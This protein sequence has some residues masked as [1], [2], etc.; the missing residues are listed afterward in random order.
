MIKLE[1]IHSLTDF[2]RD[3]KT[4][5]KNLKKT[6]R[7]VVLTVNGKATLI[8]QEASAYQTMLDSVERSQAI[9]G[10]QRGL[11]SANRGENEPAGKVFARLRKKHSSKKCQHS[12][13]VAKL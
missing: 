7:P 12:Q 2:Q 9:A 13:V 10:I 4:H 8:V 3:T 11:D 5:I 6:G 1:D